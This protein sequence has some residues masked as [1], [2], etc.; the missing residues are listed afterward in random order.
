[1]SRALV[2]MVALLAAVP[3]LAA[4]NGPPKNLFTM[5]NA[6]S[7]LMHLRLHERLRTHEGCKRQVDWQRRQRRQDRPGRRCRETSALTTTK[8]PTA[9]QPQAGALSYR[10]TRLPR[11]FLDPEITVDETMSYVCCVCC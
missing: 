6:R 2:S 11:V 5:Q 8:P 7:H 4:E 9:R 10:V 3:A 1:M